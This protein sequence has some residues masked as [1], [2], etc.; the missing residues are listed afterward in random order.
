MWHTASIPLGGNQ[1]RERRGHLL[2]AP[3]G[4]E[5]PLPR[6]FIEHGECPV[7]ERASPRFP[8]DSVVEYD[9]SDAMRSPSFPV[10]VF[11]RAISRSARY[12]SRYRARADVRYEEN[13]RCIL[14]RHR[15]ISHR[16]GAGE[17]PIMARTITLQLAAAW[18]AR[19]DRIAVRR[20]SYSTYYTAR[21]TARFHVNA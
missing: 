3:H 1:R 17:P 10:V 18:F 16:G 7:R 5:V 8:F 2:E 20:V 19:N 13:A 15:I 14:E 9:G 4:T 12:P 6:G 21:L 11:A